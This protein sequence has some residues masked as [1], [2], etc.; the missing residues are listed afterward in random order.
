MLQIIGCASLL[1]GVIGLLGSQRHKPQYQTL[2]VVGMGLMALMTFEFVGQVMDST[3][4]ALRHWQPKICVQAIKPSAQQCS[5]GTSL[6]NSLDHWLANFTELT[7]GFV[8]E[9][10]SI[11]DWQWTFFNLNV[12]VRRRHRSL[13]KVHMLWSIWIELCKNA[14]DET[15]KKIKIQMLAWWETHNF[16]T[17]QRSRVT[18]S[19]CGNSMEMFT[20]SMVLRHQA[21][22]DT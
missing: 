3:D 1:F 13:E 15:R 19:G 17:R 5:G 18:P 4:N 12:G 16:E 11:P 7:L 21:I 6:R 2:F 10:H 14:D 9:Q 20:W 22:L 8:S